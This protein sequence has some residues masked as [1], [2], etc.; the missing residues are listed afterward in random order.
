MCLSRFP[1][2]TLL[3]QPTPFQFLKRLTKYLNSPRIFIKRDDVMTLGAG[4]NKVRKLEFLLADALE[5]GADTII[6]E[7]GLQSN[8]AALL[9]AACA[10][11]N[12]RCEVVLKRLVP[13]FDEDYERSGN[14]LLDKLFGARLHIVA[15]KTDSS[16]LDKFAEQ[17]RSEGGKPY[18]IPFGG[19]TWIGALGYVDC[20]N[21]IILQA[22]AN[23]LAVK[24]LI[25][26]TGTAGTHAGLLAGL[27]E[28]G[29]NI[30]VAGI[31]VG[32]VPDTEKLKGYL[33][34]LL[35]KLLPILHRTK[36]CHSIQ[37]VCTMSIL[38]TVMAFRQ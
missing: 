4:G 20:A 25:L 7:G 27:I 33:L 12:L 8:T 34:T 19:S 1:R 26:A 17:V 24:H 31:S 35:R 30:S 5:K 23:N 2:L 16:F 32:A 10:K 22:E 18:I 37:F 29:S 3:E 13:R 36:S 9:A 15:D 28:R 11:L 14:V 38:E 21:E 6:T